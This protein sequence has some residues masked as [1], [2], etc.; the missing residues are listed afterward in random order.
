[1]SAAPRRNR[2][3]EIM[4]AQQMQSMEKKETTLNDL[5]EEQKKRVEEIARQIDV[6]D[7]QSVIQFGVG[8]QTGVSNFADTILEGMQSKDTGYVGDI[9]TDL[10]VQVKSLNVD[11]LSPSGGVMSKIPIIGSIVEGMKRFV[12]KYETVNVQIE[13]ITDELTKA[14]MQLLKDITMF[15]GLY[16][17]NIDYIRDIDLYILAGKMRLREIQDK[18]LPELRAK[19][20]Q[21]GDA[22]DAQKVQDLAQMANRLDKKVH[23]LQLSRM[24]AIQTSPQIRLIQNNDQLLVEKIQSSILNTIPLWKNQV[25]IAIGIYR[26]KKALE[27]QKEISETTNELLKKNAEMLKQGSLDIA[28]ESEKGIVEIETLKKVHEQLVSTIEETLKIQREGSVKRREA[29]TELTKLE[30]E[31]KIKLR[32]AQQSQPGMKL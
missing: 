11:K 10:M 27:M 13:K 14:R 15:D 17:R 25:V 32:E 8:A 2:E 1:V 5:N 20:E 22:I 31:L 30:G 24:I 23:D 21:S 19:A 29:E 6:E 4:E 7:S 12:A 9:L 18:A 16:D 3:E 26:Q 28:K